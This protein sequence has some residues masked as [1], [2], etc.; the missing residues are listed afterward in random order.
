MVIPP[1]RLE[2]DC[3]L[4]LS[5]GVFRSDRKIVNAAN[6]K[7]PGEMHCSALEI[8][9]NGTLSV[10]TLYSE[11]MVIKNNATL[12]GNAN[13]GS[14]EVCGKIVGHLKFVSSDT[15]TATAEIKELTKVLTFEAV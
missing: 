11:R 15:I 12:I 14:V 8:E 10:K 5:N 4:N 7:C 3:T 2:V 1:L 9:G 6:I 13:C